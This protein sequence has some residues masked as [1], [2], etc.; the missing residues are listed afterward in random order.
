MIKCLE[1]FAPL[2]D[3]VTMMNMRGV[4]GKKTWKCINI[5]SLGHFNYAYWGEISSGVVFRSIYQEVEK[6]ETLVDKT[7]FK[8]EFWVMTPNTVRRVAPANWD[9]EKLAEK[10]AHSNSC[11]IMLD[12]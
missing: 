5:S 6:I 1:S 8:I 3:P 12:I 7:N 9:R 10:L 11:L 2:S 4:T